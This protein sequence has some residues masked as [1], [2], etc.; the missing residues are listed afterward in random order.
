MNDLW[1]KGKCVTEPKQSKAKQ[2]RAE[3]SM[4]RRVFAAQET[5]NAKHSPPVF[6]LAPNLGPD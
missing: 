3:Q 2:S 4:A 6:F 1:A 5:T